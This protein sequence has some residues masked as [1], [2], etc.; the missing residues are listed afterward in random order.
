MS[1]TTGG[2]TY[3]LHFDIRAWFIGLIDRAEECRFCA[4]DI[5][6][7]TDTCF[8]LGNDCLKRRGLVWG[9]AKIEKKS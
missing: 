1:K 3:V 4:A 7:H 2:V 9:G 8:K 6:H 5:P